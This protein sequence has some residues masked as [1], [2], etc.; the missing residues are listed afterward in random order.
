MRLA[1]ERRPALLGWF[2]AEP[3]RL[4]H[5]PGETW[6]QMT[7]KKIQTYVCRLKRDRVL[8][9]SDVGGFDRVSCFESASAVGQALT[10]NVPHE[11]TWSLLLDGQNRL[12]GAV[13]LAEGGLHGCALRPSDIMRPALLAAA[14]GFVLIHNHP[15]GDPT[16]SLADIELT[17]EVANA[18]ELLGVFLLDHVIVTR[19]GRASSLRDLELFPAAGARSFGGAR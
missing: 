1:R 2:P 10:R 3:A 14:S 17:R 6:K 12:I 19:G 7:D 11:Q 13:M 18:A 8:R 4:G 9:V 15:S 16:P 5:Q